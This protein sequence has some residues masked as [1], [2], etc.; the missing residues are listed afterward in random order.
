[1][2]KTVYKL[3][4]NSI[5][6]QIVSDDYY[7]S[8]NETFEKP[9]DGIYQPFSFK[10]GVIIGATQEEFENTVQ[11]QSSNGPKSSNELVADLAQQLATSQILQDKTNAQLIKQNAMLVKQVADL[12]SEKETTN[13]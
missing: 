1:M 11:L 10:N 6:T 13:G 12:Q 9:I 4:D 7:L 5:Q 8:A 2:S 3:V